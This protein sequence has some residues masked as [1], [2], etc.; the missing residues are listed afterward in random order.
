MR[1]EGERGADVARRRFGI[2]VVLGASAVLVMGCNPPNPASAGNGEQLRVLVDRAVADN[3]HVPAAALCLLSPARGL[4]W[5]GA[6]GLADPERGET[7]T[8]DRPVRIASNT[9]TYV[10]ATVLR[11]SEE[12]LL[13]L[14]DPIA[15]H[16][17]DRQ[18][19]LLTSDG[20]DPEK[21]KVRHLLTHTSGLFDHSDSQKYGDAI[22][23]EPT[24]EWTRDEQLEAAVAWGDPWGEP[25][26][27]YT[28]CDTGYVLL[29]GIIEEAS[30]KPMAAA[31][32]EFL[33]LDH[34]GLTSTWWE[35]LEQAP[36]GVPDRAHQFIDEADVHGFSPS[37]DLFG[38]GGIVATVG[39][40]ARFYQALFTGRVFSDPATLDL[41]LTTVEGARA[42]PDADETALAPGAYRMG[43]WVM[44]IEGLTAYAHTGFWGTAVAYVPEL[45][46][47]IAA[48]VNQNKA[49]EAM[50][51]LVE[52][53]VS[54]A[55]G[56]R[57]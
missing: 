18:V 43:L 51:E 4:E 36:R 11:L 53:S 10:A 44:E 57:P 9:K 24:R 49:K 32:R 27:I 20:Y 45:D 8:A 30:G 21:I 46:L 5:S 7:M 22:L 33:H 52:G 12:G 35:I 26:E 23:A 56:A 34:I 40:M 54:V 28:Y 17:T 38:G 25:G 16:L 6:A 41:M 13:G 2:G 47:A 37:F 55:A 39:D 3:E 50:W 31:V 42:R 19:R 14:D 1:L 29:G 48:T 15:S